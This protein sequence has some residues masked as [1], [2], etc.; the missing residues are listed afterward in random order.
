MKE[1]D[2][3]AENINKTEKKKYYP[4]DVQINIAMHLF[5]NS[6]QEERQYDTHTGSTYVWSNHGEDPAITKVAA[7]VVISIS[8]AF[9]NFST[10]PP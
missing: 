10:L 3:D 1:T 4:K 6:F 5:A 7:L 8:T 9:S 2:T